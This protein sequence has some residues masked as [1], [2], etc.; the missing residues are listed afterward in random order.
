M[1][2][3]YYWPP[4]ECEWKRGE[5]AL[6]PGNK[7]GHHVALDIVGLLMEGAGRAGPEG[8]GEARSLDLH[9]GPHHHVDGVCRMDRAMQWPRE[10]PRS[11][12]SSD[13]VLQ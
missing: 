13:E 1:H 12:A 5:W 4:R 9:V 10:W 6:N 3:A 2:R 7:D 8:E 11:T